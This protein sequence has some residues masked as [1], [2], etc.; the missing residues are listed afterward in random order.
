M[1]IYIYI[2]IYN[3]KVL[4]RPSPHFGGAQDARDGLTAQ[5][6]HVAGG[7]PIIIIIIIIII[8]V[9]TI[10]IIIIIIIIH[11]TIMI[12]IITSIIIT[13]YD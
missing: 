8:I 2:Y 11:I 4:C 12:H 3:T 9:I 7:R 10:T 6:Y 1:Y 13:K 5:G